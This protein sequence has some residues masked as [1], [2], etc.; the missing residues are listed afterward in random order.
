[1]E[2]VGMGMWTTVCVQTSD[3][4]SAEPAPL[5]GDFTGLHMSCFEMDGKYKLFSLEC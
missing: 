2:V 5:C 1:M 4:Q 3:N